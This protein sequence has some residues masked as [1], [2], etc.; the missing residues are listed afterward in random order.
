M[1]VGGIEF[2][3]SELRRLARAALAGGML[4]GDVA[5][6]FSAPVDRLRQARRLDRAGNRL[7]VARWWPHALA[8]A[9]PRNRAL[10][11]G[12]GPRLVWTRN[13]NYRRSARARFLANYGYGVVMGPPDAQAVPLIESPDVAIGL[14]ML[15]PDT[16]YAS[17]RHP[18]EEIYVP[19]AGTAWWQ[20]GD[21]PWRPVAPGC[22]IHHPPAVPHATRTGGSP[23]IALYLWRGEIA[24]HARLDAAG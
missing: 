11:A 2:W 12:L 16:R 15:G 14:L 7:P 6:A 9:G 23:L 5:A 10:L 19:L 24:T 13:P 20:R 8:V 3:L 1:P 22:P 18:A 17:H 4:D 21:E